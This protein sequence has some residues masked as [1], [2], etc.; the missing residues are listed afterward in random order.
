[1]VDNLA[2]QIMC[3]IIRIHPFLQA[4]SRKS[5]LSNISSQTMFNENEQ[6]RP[7]GKFN[8]QEVQW[9]QVLGTRSPPPAE[10]RFDYFVLFLNN[11]FRKIKIFYNLKVD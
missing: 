9:G 8:G 1:M 7:R 3:H 6:E 11:I 5:H 10:E 2:D 4:Q